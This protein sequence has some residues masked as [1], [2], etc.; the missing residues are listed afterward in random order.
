AIVLLLLCV[1]L[2]SKYVIEL[3]FAPKITGTYRWIRF[4]I[5]GRQLPAIQPSELCKLAYIL[6][7][8]WYLR[9]R[10]NYRNFTALVG[11]FALTVL[12]M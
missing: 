8:A 12:P 6:A 11:P 5:A 1:L 7:L 4:E 3:P 10:S 2:V 9:Y